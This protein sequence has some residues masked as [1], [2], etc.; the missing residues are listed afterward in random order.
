MPM[1]Y[2]EF[3]ERW[4]NA[5]RTVDQKKPYW[6]TYVP[7][8]KKPYQ[9]FPRFKA[10]LKYANLY[11]MYC[12][13][14]DMKMAAFRRCVEYFIEAH[15]FRKWRERMRWIGEH[16]SDKSVTL[17]KMTAYYGEDEGHKRWKTYCDKQAITNTFEYKR[18]KYG[19]TEE[20]FRAYN[21]SR[22]VTLE[23]CIRRHGESEGTKI[24]NDYCVKQRDAG[25]TLKYFQEKYGE[26]EGRKKYLEV[27]AQKANSLD[28]YIRRYGDEEGR[29]RYSNVLKN[30]FFSK[31]ALNMFKTIISELPEFVK[32]LPTYYA[33]DTSSEYYLVDK[34]NSKLYFIDFTIPSINYCIEF[35]GDFWHCN[36]T[37]YSENDVV[38]VFGEMKNVKDVW[39]KDRRKVDFIRSQGFECDV[40]WEDDYRK[41]PVEVIDRCVKRIVD[42]FKEL[43]NE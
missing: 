27:N 25:C 15:D 4:N 37:R 16:Y 41:N 19:M 38:D 2:E 31:V 6:K 13:T 11:R 1:S 5:S 18:R 43:V 17:A 8:P 35:N 12:E 40:I 22:S 28:N 34:E 9:V 42:K 30:K 26:E 36:P 7:N 23:N 10:R 24:F 32:C 20:E 39:E 3:Y 14:K 29:E 21:Q 33:S